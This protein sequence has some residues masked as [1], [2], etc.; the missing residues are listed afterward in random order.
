[1]VEVD[2]G[3]TQ[4]VDKVARLWDM[5]VHVCVWGGGGA[6]RDEGR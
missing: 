6:I 5:C 1:M 4:G 2:V 3:V